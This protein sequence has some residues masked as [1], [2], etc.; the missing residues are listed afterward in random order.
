V[1]G[2]DIL[3]RPG[4]TLA[5]DEKASVVIGRFIEAVF[6]QGGKLAIGRHSIMMGAG[7]VSLKGQDGI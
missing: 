2:A 3:N 6:L 1:E 4:A 5:G 7:P